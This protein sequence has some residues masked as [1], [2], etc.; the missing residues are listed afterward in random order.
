MRSLRWVGLVFSLLIVGVLGG[1]MT[2]LP[3]EAAPP[4]APPTLKLQVDTGSTLTLTTT[5]S[6]CLAGDIS[7]GY[8]YCYAVPTGGTVGTAPVRFTV[9]AN[10]TPRVRLADKN[11]QDKMS[12]TGVKFVPVVVS[13]TQWPNNV[14]H[15]LTLTLSGILDATTDPTAG[16][17]TINATNAGIYK[18]AVRSG[19]EF[20]ANVGSDSV[21]NTLDLRGKGTFSLANTDKAILSTSNPTTPTDR[22][23]TKNLTPLVFDIKGPAATADINWGGLNNLDMGQ[24]DPFYPEFDCRRNYGPVATQNPNAC[25]PTITQTL[26]AKIY[27]MDTLKVLSGPMDVFC[28]KCDETFSVAQTNQIKFLTGVVKVLKF[29]EPRLHRR[30]ALQAK[31]H[32]III[33]VDAVLLTTTTPSPDTECPGAQ[34]LTFNMAIEQAVDGLVIAADPTA[35][36]GIPEP[37]HFYAVISRPGVTWETARDEAVLL[38]DGW[39]LA[40]ITSEVEQLIIN[41]KLPD[42]TSFTGTNAQQYWIGGEQ[43][44][45]ETDGIWQWINGEGKFWENG[46]FNAEYQ[47]WGISGTE[48]AG[49]QPDNLGGQH[50]LSLDHRYGWRWDDNDQFLVGFIRGYVAEGPNPLVIIE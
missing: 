2:S 21:N 40:T 8:N 36:P 43:I 3:S 44:G 4:T 30:P 6:T 17:A 45:D 27:G 24:V 16:N 12:L 31:I 34:L 37:P 23:G 38:G 14:S 35:L 32:D 11:G 5:L 10:G 13:L 48:G 20:N 1:L 22:R 18:W 19:G 7:A 47:N 28:A 46:P 33:H 49:L 26:V 39:H 15:N 9:M 41:D 50:H 42:P 29:L 25:R